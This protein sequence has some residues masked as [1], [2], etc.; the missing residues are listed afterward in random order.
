[1]PFKYRL[2]IFEVEDNSAIRGHIVL[3]YFDQGRDFLFSSIHSD[4]LGIKSDIPAILVK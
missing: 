3:P 4:S 1:M 2:P